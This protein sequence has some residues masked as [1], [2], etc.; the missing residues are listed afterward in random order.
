MTGIQMVEKQYTD[1]QL[2][3]KKLNIKKSLTIFLAV[4][5]WSSSVMSILTSPITLG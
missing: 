5:V 4:V 3:N 1:Y 2:H